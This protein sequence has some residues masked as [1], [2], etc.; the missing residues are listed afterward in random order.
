MSLALVASV[1]CFPECVCVSV[2]LSPRIM[3]SVLVPSAASNTQIDSSR[4]PSLFATDLS[5]PPQL[6]VLSAFDASKFKRRSSEDRET[7]APKS[8]GYSINSI[9]A[10]E[11]RE[12]SSGRASFSSS[13]TDDEDNSGARSNSSDEEMNKLNGHELEATSSAGWTSLVAS[14]SAFSSPLVSVA[15]ENSNIALTTASVD[16]AQ[17]QQLQNFYMSYLIS[18]QLAN[19]N[20]Q[21]NP[22]RLLAQHNQDALRSVNSFGF[23]PHLQSSQ[24]SPTTPQMRMGAN[25]TAGGNPIS[26]SPNSLGVNKKQSRPTFT[27]HQIFMLEKKFEQTKYLAGSDRAQ[28]AQ[29]LNMTESQVKVWFQNRRTK[30]R[31]KEAADQALLLNHHPVESPDDSGSHNADS[32]G[33]SA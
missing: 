22:L 25:V 1:R 23:L 29:E 5:N 13:V 9:L 2:S 30:W 8:A 28:L 14:P 10:A 17:A 18:S 4:S 3:H 7:S 19:Q 31:K 32:P 20:S 33:P 21:T 15:Q 12:P 6:P 24:I 16:L 11:K 26:L 27:G